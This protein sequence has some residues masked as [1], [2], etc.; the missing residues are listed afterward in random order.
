M[1]TLF[2][3]RLPAA[4][5][6]PNSARV[7][8]DALAVARESAVAAAAPIGEL[9]IT[10]DLVE[11]PSIPVLRDGSKPAPARRRHPRAR[12]VTAARYGATRIRIRDL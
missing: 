1:P 7:G 10:T 8:R 2:Q 3:H 5:K 4:E 11:A 12:S 9:D 6:R